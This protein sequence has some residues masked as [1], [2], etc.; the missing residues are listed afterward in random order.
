MKDIRYSVPIQ[1]TEN[2]SDVTGDFII[3]GIAISS[4]ITDNGHKFLPEELRNSAGSLANRPLLMDHNSSI[5]SMIGR[6]VSSVFDEAEQ[7]IRFEAKVNDT[8]S[9]KIVKELI[10]AGDLCTV[11]VGCNV[12][13]II[14]E[15]GIFI[16]MGIKFKELSVVATPADDNA[17]FTKMGTE[18]N[19]QLVLQEA[20][21]SKSN[22]KVKQNAVSVDNK[23]N[24]EIN[25]EKEENSVLFET[26]KEDND[27]FKEEV[28]AKI[29][30]QGTLLADT[31]S[32]VDGLKEAM[33]VASKSKDEMKESMDSVKEMLAKLIESDKDESEEKSEES[34]EESKEETK[35]ES[36]EESKEEKEEEEDEESDDDNTAEEHFKIV[37]GHKSFTVVRNKY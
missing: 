30:A 35:E 20:Y 21:N 19:L 32:K 26:L 3:Q 2:F 28:T 23:L 36:K 4:T 22:H 18:C 10:L 9:G 8:K 33:D 13:E 34:E 25:M 5:N 31:L 7:V 27:K 12:Q 37:Q 11:S 16:P 24:E 6:V 15:D 14:E 29:E 1:L 17:Q